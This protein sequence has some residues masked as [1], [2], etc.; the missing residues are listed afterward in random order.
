MGGEVWGF[1]LTSSAWPSEREEG[2][3]GGR[4]RRAEAQRAAH[5]AA[6]RARDESYEQLRADGVAR[7]EA[8][9][10]AVAAS[11]AALR[12]KEEEC[13]RLASRVAEQAEMLG[14]RGCGLASRS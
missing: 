8:L 13:G 3:C 4:V 12:A 11:A 5:E 14:A 6:L 2:C 1:E 10:V 9:R 7:Q